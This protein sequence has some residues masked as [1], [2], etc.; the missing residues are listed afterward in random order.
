MFPRN[1]A[2]TPFVFL[3]GSFGFGSGSLLRRRRSHWLLCRRRLVQS[4]LFQRLAPGGAVR[5]LSLPLAL[6]RVVAI[7]KTLL[8]PVRASVLL[9]LLVREEHSSLRALHGSRRERH[10]LLE[11]RLVFVVAYRDSI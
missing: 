6:V 7:L 5:V 9:R 3:G 2:T 8:A 11:S 4:R 10:V 1:V